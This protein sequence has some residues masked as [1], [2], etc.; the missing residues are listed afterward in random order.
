MPRPILKKIRSINLGELRQSKPRS[1]ISYLQHYNF[2]TNACTALVCLLLFTEQ[3]TITVQPQTQEKT[4]GD[5]VTLSCKVDGN[6]VPTISWTINGSPL[7]V[8]GNSRISFSKNKEQ[9]TIRDVKRTDSAAYRCVA[10]NKFGSATSEA[11]SLDIQCNEN[12]MFSQLPNVAK[13]V[14]LL[15]VQSI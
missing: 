7:D 13:A 9:L 5:S 15:T 6:P 3:P 12:L 11:A 14:P 1:Q 2:S 8:K 4:E 10:S